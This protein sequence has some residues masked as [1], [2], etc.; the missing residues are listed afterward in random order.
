[1]QNV[2]YTTL[3]SSFECEAPEIR[4]CDRKNKRTRRSSL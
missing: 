1:M 3:P 2:E 4:N